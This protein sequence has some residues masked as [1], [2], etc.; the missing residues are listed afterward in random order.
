MIDIFRNTEDQ[1]LWYNIKKG[2]K[3]SFNELFRRYYSEL[4][5]YALK[6]YPNPDFIKECIQE[7]FVRVWETRENLSKVN[8]TKSY[9]LVS[10]RRKILT[11]KLKDTKKHH[12]ELDK[13]EIN[14][15]F[16]DENEFEKH[17][18]ITDEIREV[19]LKAVN[20]LTSRQRELV[21]L[22]FYHE[23]PY[24]EIAQ[25]IGI[26]IQAVRNLMYRT[27]IH[28][29]ESI[30]ERSLHSMRNTFFLLFSLVSEKK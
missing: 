4:Y 9:L 17:D 12:V 8:N 10:L 7:V 13:T 15:F 29:R 20:S 26:S 24:S 11:A 14:S 18:E 1:V 6:I 22:F 30:G 3:S 27:L 5:F 19:V 2:D 25:V 21:M 23:L 28:L 16:F